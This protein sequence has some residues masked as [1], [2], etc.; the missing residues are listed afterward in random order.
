M[1]PDF[2]SGKMVFAK[3]FQEFHK[4]TICAKALHNHWH[5]NP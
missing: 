4:T 2:L 5:H 1:R 3:L